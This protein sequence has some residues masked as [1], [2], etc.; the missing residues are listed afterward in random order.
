MEREINN[1]R[2]DRTPAAFRNSC[3]MSIR[4]EDVVLRTIDYVK[5]D[6]GLY[7]IEVFIEMH[8]SLV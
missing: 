2:R 4:Q 1:Q 6:L 7:T 3:H 5:K 8:S